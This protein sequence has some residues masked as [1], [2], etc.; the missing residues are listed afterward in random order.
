MHARWLRSTLLLV[1]A[2]LAFVGDAGPWRGWGPPSVSAGSA[3]LGGDARGL[4]AVD[5]PD[6]PALLGAYGARVV[7]RA[8]AAGPASAQPRCPE[9]SASSLS[10]I[11][12]DLPSLVLSTSARTQL[13][14]ARRLSM[15][16]SGALSSFGTSLPPPLSA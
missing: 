13:T 14:V 16:N 10:A 3:P 4:A 11:F 2:A 1:L 12:A 7:L 8:P 9:R 15:A 6:L 5:V